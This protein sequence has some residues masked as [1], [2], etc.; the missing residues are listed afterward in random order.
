MNQRRAEKKKKKKKKLERSEGKLM[1]DL[2]Q[3]YS[4]ETSH[5]TLVMLIKLRCHANF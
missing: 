5:L 3:F 4:H 1:G 2:K